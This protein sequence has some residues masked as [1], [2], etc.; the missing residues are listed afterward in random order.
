MLPDE[1]GRQHLFTGEQSKPPRPRA[2]GAGLNAPHESAFAAD[3][4]QLAVRTDDRNH[5]HSRPRSNVRDVLDACIGTNGNDIRDHYICSS[6]G[7]APLRELS[8]SSISG[9]FL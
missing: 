3:T 8:A 6:H 1:L 4:K 5:T 9:R 7:T 2:A